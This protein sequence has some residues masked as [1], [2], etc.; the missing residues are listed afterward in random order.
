MLSAFF[1]L[2]T[3]EVVSARVRGVARDMALTKA[4]LRQRPALTVEQVQPL[5]VARAPFPEHLAS[6]IRVHF[7]TL[8]SLMS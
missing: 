1:F 8:G 5:E 6:E 4:P 3:D 7:P 2:R